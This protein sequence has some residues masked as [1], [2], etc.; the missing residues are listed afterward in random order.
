MRPHLTESKK[1][2]LNQ[3]KKCER[4]VLRQSLNGYGTSGHSAHNI[5]KDAKQKRVRKQ[6]W[7]DAVHANLCEQQLF[8]A[9][10]CNTTYTTNHTTC[11]RQQRPNWWFSVEDSLTVGC[12]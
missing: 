9:A 1:Q 2:P 10:T 8:T 12:W 5:A 4:T 7:L 3:S 11:K 6:T